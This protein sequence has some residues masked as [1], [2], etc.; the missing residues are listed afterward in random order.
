MDIFAFSQAEFL[1][2]ILT[3]IRISLIVFL[4]PFFGGES[5]PMQVKACICLV[6]TM[7]VWPRLSLYIG[8]T[9]P[10][11][12]GLAIIIFSELVLGLLLGLCVQ[13]VFA[14]VQ[15]GGEMLGFQMGFTMVAIIDPLSGARISVTSQ[16][17]YMVTMLIFLVFNGHLYL[18]QA[19]AES[20]DL[21]PPGGLV[22]TSSV[23]STV[24]RLS[25]DMFIL[26]LKI[27]S[28]VLVALFM[29]ELTLALMGRAAP[30]MNLM[31][32][33]F[34]IKISVGFFF[35][36]FLFT[37]M[38]GRMQSFIVEMGPLF[39]SLLRMGSPL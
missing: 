29:V 26:A 7:A 35:L 2:F 28:P 14:A 16:V 4:L 19:L 3:F 6:L 33:G 31:T 37:V 17:L 22:V 12:L 34:P 8:D 25:G 38:S 11:P 13:F 39:K 9:A 27:A 30:Q 24:I 36:S 20:F 21:I 18:L 15:T 5:I 10:H 23:T 1:S 32:L